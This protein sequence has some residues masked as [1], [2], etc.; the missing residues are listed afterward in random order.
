MNCPDH[1]R[2]LVPRAQGD[3]RCPF[4]DGALMTGDQLEQQLPGAS[5]LL[6]V[7]RS[8]PR[9]PTR[10][11]PECAK[12]MRRLRIGSSAA[13]LEACPSCERL[14]VEK[15]DVRTLQALLK[16]SARQ[17]AYAGL[18][19][20][21][22]AAMAGELAEAVTQAQPQT[23][24]I[25]DQALAV[26]GVPVLRGATGARAPWLTRALAVGL[27]LIQCADTADSLAYQVGS[28]SVS[29]LFIAGLAHFGWWHLIGNVLTLLVFGSSAERALPRWLFAL[30]VLCL[31]P[32]TIFAEALISSDGMLVGGASGLVAACIGICLLIHPRAKVTLYALRFFTVPLW[33]YGAGWVLFQ[34]SLWSLGFEGVAWLAHLV[35]FAAGLCLGFF[36]REKK[37]TAGF[38][39]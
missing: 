36:A 20:D 7:E 19:A 27:V 15:A 10:V 8:P 38:S 37:V 21:E 30:V 33:A 18:P 32:M 5:A 29:S 25:E 26:I 3:L 12:P 4:C 31:T 22:R 28:G 35:G 23:L 11:C 16:R 6:E 1:N 24:A 9:G 13:W 2:A 39:R 34:I 17:T 14:W